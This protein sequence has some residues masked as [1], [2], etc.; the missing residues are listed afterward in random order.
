M[1]QKP[2]LSVW[3]KE[4]RKFS[5]RLWF[6]ST[7]KLHYLF[8]N[9]NET[10]K[11]SRKCSVLIMDVMMKFH[12]MFVFYIFEFWGVVIWKY[13]NKRRNSLAWDKV[14]KLGPNSKHFMWSQNRCV[15]TFLCVINVMN[16]W[17][18]KQLSSK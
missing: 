5:A 18:P 2:G 8:T 1:V 15:N 10:E 4:S 6:S 16:E 17:V 11:R 14:S 3:I 7:Q 13:V 9:H 12:K